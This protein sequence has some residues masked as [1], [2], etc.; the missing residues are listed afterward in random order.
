[1]AFLW[2]RYADLDWRVGWLAPAVGAVVF[3]VWIG[4]DPFTSAVPESMPAP[5]AVASAPARNL[6]LLFRVLAAVT[7]VPLA[8]ELAFRG[9]LYRRLLSPD[10][11]SV[12]FRRFSW[13]ALLIGSALFGLLHG[14]RWF[15][16]ALAGAAYA[17]VMMRRGSIA[18]AV[19][20]HATTNALLAVDI[21]AFHRW[22]LW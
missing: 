16:G 9:F 10:F 1:L 3:A 5:L 2:R 11:E 22:H 15:V 12:S 20:A 14:D 8:E 18:D 4:L 17:L 19:V 21:L 6:W 7:T 13:A